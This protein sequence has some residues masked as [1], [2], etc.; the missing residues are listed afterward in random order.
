MGWQAPSRFGLS[1]GGYIPALPH[2]LGV[3][4]GLVSPPGVGEIAMERKESWA[5]GAP[6]VGLCDACAQYVGLRLIFLVP[7][8]RAHA[9]PEVDR[10]VARHLIGSHFCREKIN[11]CDRWWKSRGV[12]RRVGVSTP[13]PPPPP[14]EIGGAVLAIGLIVPHLSAFH[15]PPTGDGFRSATSSALGNR[16]SRTMG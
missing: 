8:G 6:I 11:P 14:P 5:V 9:F 10:A 16:S 1:C 2:V 15:S 12:P 13:P 3:V 4:Y 7:G